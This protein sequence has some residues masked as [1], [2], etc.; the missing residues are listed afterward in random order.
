MRDPQ[1][2]IRAL[3]RGLD[4]IENLAGS[5][6]MSLAA[7]RR[8][9]GLSNA[10][11]L[12]ILATLQARGWVRRSLVDAKYEL[13]HETGMFLRNARHAHPL[14]EAASPTMRDLGDSGL[15]YPSDL[16]AVQKPGVI[17]IV[18]TNRK[19]GP[20]AP[21]HAPYGVHPSMLFSAHGKA[22]IAFSDTA[23]RD[24]HLTAIRR[25]GTRE[26]RLWLDSGQFDAA[27]AETR[28]VGYG[29]RAR[30]YWVRGI[31]DLPE[32]G[33]I[34]MPIFSQGHVAATISVLWLE[35]HCSL[36]EIVQNGIPG[37]L[38]TAAA[39]IAANL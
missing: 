25:T 7:L 30:E 19:K 12:R 36:A 32:M 27:I 29:V 22:F 20:H 9:S 21:V 18:E 14:A 17:E 39:Q 24:L 35:E 4:I 6:R 28:R 38:E 16:A 5:G 26:E 23:T 10:T 11:L 31:E 15:P 8:G 33:A 2:Q 3:G 1:K 13:T 34:A 37:I